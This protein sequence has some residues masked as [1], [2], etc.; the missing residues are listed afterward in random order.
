MPFVSGSTPLLTA[1]ANSQFQAH[2]L[3]FDTRASHVLHL[4]LQRSSRAVFLGGRPHRS[5]AVELFTTD[6]CVNWL[7]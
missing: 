4:G 3:R 5:P 6:A 1:I 2:T 7:S